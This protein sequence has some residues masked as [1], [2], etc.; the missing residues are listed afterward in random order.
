MRVFNKTNDSFKIPLHHILFGLTLL[1][2]ASLLIWWSIF[3]GSSIRSKKDQQYRILR[4]ELRILCSNLGADSGWEPEVGVCSRDSRFEIV[5]SR[6]EDSPFY[7]TLAP[8]RPDFWVRPSQDIVNQ[9]EKDTRRKYSMLVG[10]AGFLIL[11]ILIISIFLFRSI[12]VERRT[13]R[14]IM[15]F[16]ERTAHEI[17]TPITGIKAFLQHLKSR[18]ETK[19]LSAYVDLAMKQVERQEKLAENILSGYR[20]EHRK[21][22]LKPRE[23]DL[24]RFLEDYLRKNTLILSGTE[25]KLEIPPELLPKAI[26]D[27]H[28]LKVILDNLVDNAVKYAS[29]NLVLTFIIYPEKKYIVLEIRDNGPGFLPVQAENLFRAFELLDDELEIKRRGAGMGLYIS[30]ALAREMGGDL[31]ASSP[32][33]GLGASF[34]I[35]LEMEKT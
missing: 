27:V 32:G 22:G 10:E 33:K 24:S 4:L 34:K 21:A 25:V 6:N 12:Q 3:I 17:K 16:W 28:A 31:R 26:A 35:H 14:E 13:T 2:L 8:R 19:D 30:R 9:I 23:V 20:L 29:P 1:S 18:G 11:I 5:Q 7:E 15:E